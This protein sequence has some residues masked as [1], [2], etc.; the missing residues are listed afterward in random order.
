LKGEFS[1]N[2]LPPVSTPASI[3]VVAGVVADTTAVLPPCE[4]TWQSAGWPDMD[5]VAGWPR[6]E[7]ILE[8]SA[9]ME[10]MCQTLQVSRLHLQLRVEHHPAF[11]FQRAEIQGEMVCWSL[12]WKGEQVWCPER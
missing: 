6:Q 7:R 3:A 11:C 5:C 8:G 9:I 4:H 12:E 10:V 2:Q 1:P